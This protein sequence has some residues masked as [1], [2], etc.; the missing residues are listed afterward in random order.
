MNT[1]DIIILFI[2]AYAVFRGVR[3]GLIIQGLAIVGIAVG[4]WFGGKF[5]DVLAK[6]IGIKGEYSSLWGFLIVLF[7]SIVAVAVGARLL[8]KVL[9]YAG[10]G[11]LDVILGAALSVCK[12]LLI[13][14]VLFTAFDYVNK[15][16]SVADK[17]II[18]NSLFYRPIANITEW[19]DPA[20]DWTQKHL[21]LKK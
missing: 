16:Y 12:F 1:I 7:I 10:F 4:M 15:I 21:N 17:K 14:S 20:W 9:H 13:L 2:L 18:D 3:D 6:L 8:R 5:G 11:L 19:V